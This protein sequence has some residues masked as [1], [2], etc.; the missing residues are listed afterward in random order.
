[1]K[2]LV[3][4]LYNAGCC[5]RG[6]PSSFAAG[7]QACIEFKLTSQEIA[8]Q[9]QSIVRSTANC[10]PVHVSPLKEVIPGYSHSPLVPPPQVQVRLQQ[11]LCVKVLL[12]YAMLCCSVLCTR[13]DVV[14]QG[15]SGSRRGP[16]HPFGLQA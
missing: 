5:M 11:T 6:H 9:R 2:R 1:M 10:K 8:I 13:C 4:L 14:D 7:E 12:C 15:G 3:Q 16:R